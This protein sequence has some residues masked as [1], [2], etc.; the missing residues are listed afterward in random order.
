MVLEWYWD[1]KGVVR[2]HGHRNGASRAHQST[3]C[4]SC[5]RDGLL[6][7][8]A[9]EPV[10]SHRRPSVRPHCLVCSQ[11]L[12]YLLRALC[13][14]QWLR[15]NRRC[16]WALLCAHCCFQ[17]PTGLCG[18]TARHC[19]CPHTQG[20]GGRPRGRRGIAAALARYLGPPELHGTARTREYSVHAF[21]LPTSGALLPTAPTA[22]TA[23]QP[24]QPRQPRQPNGAGSFGRASIRS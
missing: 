7:I 11:P 3:A 22:P 12:K 2:K 20:C 15:K 1:Q 6:R 17:R 10:R 9:R 5:R 13:V 23:P 24:R 14:P 21:G 19:V 8:G 18:V 4:L 16:S